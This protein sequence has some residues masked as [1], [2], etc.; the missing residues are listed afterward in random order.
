MDLIDLPV[1][2]VD[3]RFVS[4]RVSRIIELIREYSPNLDVKWIPPDARQNGEAAFIITEKTTNGREVIAFSVQ[5][6]DEFDERVLGRIIA[7]DT[8]KNDVEGRIEA[9]N[10]AVRAVQCKRYQEWLEEQLEVAKS[11]LRSPKDTYIGPGG[12]V[13]KA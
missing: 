5:T 6:E 1:P 12:K 11:V 4:G 3:G 7:A 10:A 9:N 13:Y 2:H 8:N